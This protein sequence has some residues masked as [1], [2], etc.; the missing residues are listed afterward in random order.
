MHR[1][2][3]FN[4]FTIVVSAESCRI[5]FTYTC[6][7]EYEIIPKEIIQ[8]QLCKQVPVFPYILYV[9]LLDNC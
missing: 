9:P 6:K 1:E 5:P 4:K 2:V 7:E 8:F 3:L